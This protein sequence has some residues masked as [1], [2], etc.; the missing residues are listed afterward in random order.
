MKKFKYRLETFLK[1]K[2]NIEKQKQRE[3]AA[4]SQKVMNQKNVLREINDQNSTTLDKKRKISSGKIS[5]SEMLI[6]SRYILK[7]KKDNVTGVEL[8]RA[9]N[10]TQDE[11]RLDLLEASK[12][13]KIYEKLKENDQD[14][15]NKEIKELLQKESDEIGI[16]GFRYKKN[17]LNKKTA[18]K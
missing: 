2:E 13:K 9:L 3:L 11:K 16:N 15:F 12:A 1:V 14:T 4:A 17:K 7:L 6:Y 10:K 18:I 5:V 8:L